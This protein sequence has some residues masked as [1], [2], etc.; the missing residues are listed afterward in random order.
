[1]IGLLENTVF[2]KI[3]LVLDW[4]RPARV[5]TETDGDIMGSSSSPSAARMFRRFSSRL[6]SLSG[7]MVPGLAEAV[8]AVVVGV[9][10][11]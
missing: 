5:L 9:R 1:M 11:R 2:G 6:G 4:L 7:I 3:I 10:M 8:E